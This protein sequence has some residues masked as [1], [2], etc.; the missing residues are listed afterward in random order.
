MGIAIEASLL[1]GPWNKTHNMKLL[2]TSRMVC[3]SPV[4]V[5]RFAGLGFGAKGQVFR[6]WGFQ[7]KPD[8]LQLRD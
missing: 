5:S 3:M 8:S 2:Y 6:G 7:G 4:S 1:W